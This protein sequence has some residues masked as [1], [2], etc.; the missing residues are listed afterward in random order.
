MAEKPEMYHMWFRRTIRYV[1]I[2]G[3]I[4]SNPYIL[5]TELRA[6]P[7]VRSRAIQKNII[8]IKFRR[9]GRY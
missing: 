2:F 7:F 4:F 1:G 3:D 6:Y 9:E 5:V 8:E